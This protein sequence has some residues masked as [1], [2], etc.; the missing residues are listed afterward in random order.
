MAVLVRSLLESLCFWCFLQSK[1]EEEV[2][3]VVVGG[4]RASVDTV[5]ADRR[6]EPLRP[7]VVDAFLDV[8]DPKLAVL[9]ATPATFRAVRV[10]VTDLGAPPGAGS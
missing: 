6:L 9:Q 5:L 2:D 1:V 8:P 3:A 10:D 4:D 7:L